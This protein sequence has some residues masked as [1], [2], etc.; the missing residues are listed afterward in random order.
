M[1]LMCGE[2]S[3]ENKEEKVKKPEYRH[4]IYNC[5]GGKSGGCEK[6][7]G[8]LVMYKEQKPNSLPFGAGHFNFT[9]L[10]LMSYHTNSLHPHIYFYKEGGHPLVES[11]AT[12][13]PFH[14]APAF[15]AANTHTGEREGA[16]Y[17]L[18]TLSQFMLKY[19]CPQDM[20]LGQPLLL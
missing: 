14:Q 16:S 3:K 8:K 11:S 9:T 4:K 19:Q 17:D 1:H 2:I 15:T 10:E 20:V 6:I 13:S 5:S 12:A 7:I 18:P